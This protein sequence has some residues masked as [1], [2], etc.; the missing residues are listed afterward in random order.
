VHKFGQEIKRRNPDARTSWRF[1]HRTNDYGSV[2]NEPA[3]EAEGKKKKEVAGEKAASSSAMDL[4]VQLP[5]TAAAKSL[6]TNVI[7]MHA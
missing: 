2:I 3:S 6:D 5:L 7:D 1:Y 4:K